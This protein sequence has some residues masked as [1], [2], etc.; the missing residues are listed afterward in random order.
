MASVLCALTTSLFYISEPVVTMREG[1]S[2]ESPVVSQALFSENIQV[3]DI[4][5]NWSQIKTPEGYSGWIQ[6]KACVKCQ[7]PYQPSI[8]VSRLSAHVYKVKAIE[9]GPLC[10][11]PFG[12]QL[13]VINDEDERWLKV[14]LPNCQECFIQKGDVAPQKELKRKEDLAAFS[15]NFLGLPY[16]WGGRS[17]F[18]YDC[19]GFIQM[20]YQQIGIQ[21]PRDARQQ[22]SDAHLHPIFIDQLES[23]DLI[24]FG[25]N[26]Q[27]IMH[28]GMYLG[29]GKFIHATSRENQPWIRI[30]Q[31][32]DYEWSGNPN[33]YYPHRSFFTYF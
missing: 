9:Q 17:S 21:L 10:T 16:T 31:L 30:S 29:E 6:S 3:T 25:K 32:I 2:L 13:Q 26:E 12:V 7:K 23:G 15:Q 5:E 19:S 24:F 33:A 22:I 1:P 20:L 8:K 4:S 14:I 11:L 27:K 28:V 18:G